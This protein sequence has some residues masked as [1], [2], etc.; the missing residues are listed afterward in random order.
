MP[1][2]LLTTGVLP[3]GVLGAYRTLFT[4]HPPSCPGWYSS[5]FHFEQN[6]ITRRK[7]TQRA[8]LCVMCIPGHVS[9]NQDHHKCYV[10]RIVR[11]ISLC[12]CLCEK[13][14]YVFHDRDAMFY[15]PARGYPDSQCLHEKRSLQLLSYMFTGRINPC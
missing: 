9:K 5:F 4:H 3:P 6:W 15:A 2:L 7:K 11:R 10:V 8:V 1:L 14:V 12:L 13:C